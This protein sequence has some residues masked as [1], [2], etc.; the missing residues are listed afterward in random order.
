LHIQGE[1]KAV[2]KMIVFIMRDQIFRNNGKY[3]LNCRGRKEGGR[4]K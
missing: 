1:E 3:N 4:Q 2:I